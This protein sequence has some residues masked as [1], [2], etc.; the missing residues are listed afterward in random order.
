MSC[1]GK[2][3]IRS[4]CRRASSEFHDLD[5]SPSSSS[6]KTRWQRLCQ[7][8][9][10]YLTACRGAAASTCLRRPNVSP[11]LRVEGTGRLCLVITWR[12]TRR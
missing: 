11:S 12:G 2:R 4:E 1:A 6:H 3:A 9:L 8:D 7:V 10:L 5:T